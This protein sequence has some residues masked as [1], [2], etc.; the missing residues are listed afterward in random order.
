MINISYAA[1][2]EA[3]TEITA[4]NTQKSAGDYVTFTI[5]VKNIA[6]AAKL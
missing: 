5:S 1:T 4:D 3:T 2:L 6:N